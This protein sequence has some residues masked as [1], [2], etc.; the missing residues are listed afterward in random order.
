MELS[1]EVDQITQRLSV[2]P[3]RSH[4]AVT[5]SLFWSQLRL[6]LRD[7]PL[8]SIRTNP[9]ASTVNQ[10]ASGASKHVLVFASI[11]QLVALAPL[12]RC[13][14]A[15]HFVDVAAQISLSGFPLLQQQ[16]QQRQ[17]PQQ[18]QKHQFL[19]QPQ[20]PLLQLKKQ[21]VSFSV[22]LPDTTVKIPAIVSATTNTV[23]QGNTGTKIPVHAG[24]TSID[25]SSSIIHTRL[26]TDSFSNIIILPC[27]LYIYEV[28]SP[29]TLRT[30]DPCLGQDDCQF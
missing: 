24:T 16:P 4:V 3:L 11:S 30:Y 28:H 12:Q 9:T 23:A 25:H 27:L 10:L 17:S 18:M 15:I 13:G 21:P 20:K 6:Y 19:H 14:K 5:I 7:S 2:S 1:L 8:P 22:L 26:T 29:H